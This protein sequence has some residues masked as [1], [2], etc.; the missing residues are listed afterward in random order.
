MT[1]IPH[2]LSHIHHIW[3]LLSTSI[4][5]KRT[6]AS[7]KNGGKKTFPTFQLFFLFFLNLVLTKNIA[8]YKPLPAKHNA[9]VIQSILLIS[10]EVVVKGMH[11]RVWLLENKSEETRRK[12]KTRSG[13]AGINHSWNVWQAPACVNN[14]Q[15]FF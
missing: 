13:W 6:H 7:M 12:G 14:S 1:C 10:T 11:I 15:Y 2:A 5:S 4:Q 8:T 3:G 9:Y